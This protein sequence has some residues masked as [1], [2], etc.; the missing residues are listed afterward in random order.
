VPAVVKLHQREHAGKTDDQAP[1]QQK[2]ALE[3]V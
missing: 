2:L 3:K 1:E